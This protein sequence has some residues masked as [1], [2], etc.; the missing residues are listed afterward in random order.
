MKVSKLFWLVAF[1]GLGCQSAAESIGS[2]A[3]DYVSK[4]N[5]DRLVIEID[6]V[7]GHSLNAVTT[8]FIAQ[9]LEP[10]LDKPGGLSFEFSHSI[11]D[12]DMRQT[13]TADELRALEARHRNRSSG[14]G[15]V[16][17][18]VLVVTGA[19]AGLPEGDS[20]LALAYSKSSIVLFADA[21]A[22]ACAED[23]SRL[24]PDL[25]SLVCPLSTAMVAL[26]EIGHI[27]GL[28]DNGAPL[29]VPH[30]DLAHG[31]HCTGGKC[32]MNWQ[33]NSPYMV[34]FVQQ[35]FVIDNEQFPLFGS[36]CQAD[37]DQLR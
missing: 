20:I 37:L 13:Y 5:Y 6:A 1:C 26:H 16:T 17:L 22:D 19:Y 18:Y 27:L 2:A 29:T 25:R 14:D 36:D 21:I 15:V 30:R 32:I 28:V 34:G 11:P 24:A 4:A 9:E 12:A 33:N 23:L 35:R 10:L 7:G 3:A 8:D 31:H